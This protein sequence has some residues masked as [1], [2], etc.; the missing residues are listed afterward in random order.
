[1]KQG[2]KDKYDFGAGRAKALR[3]YNLF[4]LKN[5]VQEL[6]ST[7]QFHFPFH[8]FDIFAKKKFLLSCLNN[9]VCDIKQY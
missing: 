8:I 6:T 3:T 7:K 2:N 9:C 5:V 1:V 4:N